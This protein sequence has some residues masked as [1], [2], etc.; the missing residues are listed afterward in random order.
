V[1]ADDALGDLGALGDLR[2]GGP[3]VAGLGDDVG[4]IP[5]CIV[6]GL[7]VTVLIAAGW[8]AST[9]AARREARTSQPEAA[10]PES[11]GGPGHEP[12]Y[13]V[14]PPDLPHYHGAGLAART[15]S[16]PA[17]ERTQQP[18]GEGR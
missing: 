12:A 6:A 7:I 2:H 11:G 16:A 3:G 10:T 15:G 18:A 1:V 13:P 8:A 9:A 5:V 4:G 17:A 14:P